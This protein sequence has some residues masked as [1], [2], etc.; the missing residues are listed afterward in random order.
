MDAINSKLLELLCDEFPFTQYEA[1]DIIRSAP[2]RYQV[3]TI[4]KRN[5]RGTR[6]IAQPTSELKAIQRWIV[7]KYIKHLPVHDSAMAYRKNKNIA[8]HARIHVESKYL[9]KIDFKDFFPSIKSRDFTRHIVNHLKIESRL[10]TELS[11]LLFRRDEK[12]RLTLSIGAPSSPAISN[13]LLY[14]FDLKLFDYCRER[15]IRYSRYADDLALSTNQPHIL[16]DAYEFIKSLLKEIRYPRITINLEKTV[17]TSR[18]FQR[19]LTG[20]VLSSEGKVSLGREKKRLIRSMAN[21]FKKGVLDPKLIGRLKGFLAFALSVEPDFVFNIRKTLG[22]ELYAE[23]LAFN[24]TD[25]NDA[26][27]DDE[28]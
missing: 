24:K 23:L 11:Y 3:H 9:L 20:L 25:D 16:D 2:K 19:K 21:H 12:R 5:G 28:M 22:E 15:N 18:K 10:A 17:F 7:E 4:T 8:H 14:E 1:W 26:A 27:D 6:L 13:T